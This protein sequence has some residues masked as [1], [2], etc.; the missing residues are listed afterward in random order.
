MPR[1]PFVPARLARRV[2]TLADARASGL[3][4]SALKERSWMRLGPQI[5]CRRVLQPD[6]WDLLAAHRR[7]LPPTALFAGNTAAWMH[8]LDAEPGKP[9]HVILP[10]GSSL[11]SH[12]GLSVWRSE[13]ALRDTAV[14]RGFAVTS[15]PR[16]LLDVCLRFSLPEALVLVDM[17]VQRGKTDPVALTRHANEHSGRAGAARLRLI[18]GLAAPAESPMESRLRWVLLQAGIP[19]PEVQGEVRDRAGRFLARADLLFRSARLVV[20]FDGGNHRERLV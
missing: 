18:A 17:A 5:Y 10:V 9:V 4:L 15:L 1:K 20:E 11:R 3:T 16:T 14:V 7:L 13:V 19:R 2:F 12:A 6:P 8:G